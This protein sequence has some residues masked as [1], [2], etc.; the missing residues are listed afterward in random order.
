MPDGLVQSF[1]DTVGT[2]ESF[3]RGGTLGPTV[4][5]DIEGDTATVDRGYG[6]D[7]LGGYADVPA[8][9]EYRAGFTP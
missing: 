4:R 1:I 3:R 6:D 9:V 8:N 5:L 7:G 2:S